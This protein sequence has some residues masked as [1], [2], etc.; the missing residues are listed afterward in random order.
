MLTQDLD[1]LSFEKKY[2]NFLQILDKNKKDSVLGKKK[3]EDK[4]RSLVGAILI[5]KA[6]DDYNKAATPYFMEYIPNSKNMPI[7]KKLKFA[8][9][10]DGK[11]YLEDFK[12]F[13]FSISH[14]KDLVCASLCHKDE[15]DKIGIDIQFKA[16]KKSDLI[17]KRF[18]SDFEKDFLDS[19][20]ECNKKDVF[21]D[22]WAAKEAY[23]KMTGDGL[24]KDFKSFDADITK[25]SIYENNKIAAKITN[26]P[27]SPIY[28]TY[29]ATPL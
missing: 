18:Y 12:D 22:I 3:D 16:G 13:A 26:I 17:A 1:N 14:S 6:I 9:A 25:G 28:S 29:I 21:F 24:K 11:P 19:I 8:Y 7:T 5:H 2:E 10:K 15:F 20:D 23:V 27:I 4:L